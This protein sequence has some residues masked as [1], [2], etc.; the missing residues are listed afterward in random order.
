MRPFVT[1]DT[2]HLQPNIEPEQRYPAGII[3]APAEATWLKFSFNSQLRDTE[4][5]DIVIIPLMISNRQV[6]SF[7]PLQYSKATTFRAIQ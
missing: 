5:D 1:G 4:W 6:G 2:G 3:R 7:V